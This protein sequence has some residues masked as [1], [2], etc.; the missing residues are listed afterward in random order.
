[1]PAKPGHAADI[2]ELAGYPDRPA[3]SPNRTARH[4]PA[5][6]THTGYPA[7]SRKRK[8]PR[9]K[10]LTLPRKASCCH[11]EPSLSFT[12]RTPFMKLRIR[13]RTGH[14][15]GAHARNGISGRL[16]RLTATTL[17]LAAATGGGLAAYELTASAPAFAHTLARTVHTHAQT[18]DPDQVTIT[19]IADRTSF[20]RAGQ[21]ITYRYEITNNGGPLGNVNVFDSLVSNPVTP[22]SWVCHIPIL[23]RGATMVVCPPAPGIG[24]R[25]NYITTSADVARGS[26]TDQATAR[27]GSSVGE[28][29]G[30][31]NTVTIECLGSPACPPAPTSGV[32]V[33]G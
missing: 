29:V 18:V 31:S 5:R 25:N 20:N 19:K 4:L 33:T 9:A 30:E 15:E 8:F 14:A 28:I 16:R 7:D 21:V 2:P 10:N 12:E 22:H 1:M 3:A 11:P 24:F 27:I 6:I 26:V 32:P 13:A 17:A 23:R